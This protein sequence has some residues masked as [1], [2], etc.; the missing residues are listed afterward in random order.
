MSKISVS[1]GIILILLGVGFY[2]GTGAKSLTAL[3]PAFL[4]AG[5]AI[6]GAL[7]IKPSRRAVFAHVALV[8]GVLGFLAGL[9]RGTMTWM[10]SGLSS[11]ATEQILMGVICAIYVFL[12]IQS[13]RAARKARGE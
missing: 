5:I 7:A 9:G 8:L 13:F 6:S 10:K 3:I 12:C 1:F 11:A 4:G 2:A